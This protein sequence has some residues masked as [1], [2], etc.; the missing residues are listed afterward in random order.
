MGVRAGALP[1]P[2]A[3][4]DD[5]FVRWACRHLTQE[6]EEALRRARGIAERF[7]DRVARSVDWRAYDVVGFSSCG[8][9]N[10]ASLALARR[11]KETHP[12]IVVVFGGADWHDVMGLAQHR[13]SP[14][15]DA[16]FTGE[17]D[18][19]LLRFMHAFRSRGLSGCRGIPGV[20]LWRGG[21]PLVE[22][23]ARCVEDLD[24]LPVPDYAEYF[25]ARAEAGFGSDGVLLPLE[26]S[27]GCHWADRA[28]C[29]FCGIVG[30]DHTYRAK[31]GPRFSRN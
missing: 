11:I 26:G 7:I 6:H 25:A 14:F 30:A 22:V 31:S 18:E 27:R 3:D 17:A 4:E 9:Q 12:G 10:V 15:V 2:D 19:S 13:Q 20:S 24:D 28:P 21:R 16:G 29:R 23:P 1:A 8:D 5:F